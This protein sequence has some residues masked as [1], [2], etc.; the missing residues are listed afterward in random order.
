MGAEVE[1]DAAQG[2]AEQHDAEEGG[3]PEE[4]G[5][6]FIGEQG[7]PD[8]WRK[9]PRFVQRV[10]AGRS[11]AGPPPRSTALH[12]QRG[13]RPLIHCPSVPLEARLLGGGEEVAMTQEAVPEDIR[14]LARALGLDRL[15]ES[16]LQQFAKAA[17]VAETRRSVLQTGALVPSDEPAHVYHPR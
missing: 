8:P 14:K 15:S 17:R 9:A 4:R 11:A 1:R 12:G 16:D 2:E 10:A 6:L 5:Q 7:P 13:G 3:F